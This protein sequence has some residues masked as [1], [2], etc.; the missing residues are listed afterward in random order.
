MILARKQPW[1][2][3]WFAKQVH[4]RLRGRFGQIYAHGLDACNDLAQHHPLVCVANHTCYWDGLVLVELSSYHLDIDAHAMMDADNL[5][6]HRFFAL[7]GAFS[8]QRGAQTEAALA[9]AAS[10]LTHPGRAAWVFPQGREQPAHVPLRFFEGAARIA[11]ATPGARVVPVAMRYVFGA[12]A[13]PDIYVHVGAP[14]V[15]TSDVAHDVLA[16]TQAVELGLRTIDA[17]QV[18]PSDAFVSLWPQ[19]RTL[20]TRDAAT[21]VLDA[22]A[23]LLLPQPLQPTGP[24]SGTQVEMAEPV[25]RMGASAMRVSTRPA[26]PLSS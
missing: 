4:T 11:A 18:T 2:E 12:Q 10:L 9:Y 16:Q 21:R 17:A 25:T 20:H 6:R 23:G 22:L 5:S 13:K 15:P 24:T 1:F 26:P 14:L 7:M 8:V 19:R 3:T